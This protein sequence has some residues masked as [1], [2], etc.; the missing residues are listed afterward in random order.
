MVDKEII[1]ALNKNKKS[2]LIDKYSKILDKAKSLVYV[3]FRGLNVKD[4]EALRKQLYNEGINYTVVKKTLWE[5]AL[6]TKNYQ[7]DKP[8]ISEE[9]AVIGGEDLLIPA[10]LANDFA[11]AHKGVFGILGGIFEGNFKDMNSMLEIAT[12]PSREVLL[13]Q[14]A[15]LFKS[16]IQRLAIGLNEVAKTKN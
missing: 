5:R 4:T 13:S 10:R 3:K 11:K 2:E 6:N 1:M 14:I 16:P 9:M 15:Y 7:G 8:E 12:I